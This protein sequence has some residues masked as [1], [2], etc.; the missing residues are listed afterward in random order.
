MLLAVIRVILMSNSG[1]SASGP[2]G[3]GQSPGDATDRSP[4]PKQAESSPDSSLN[5]GADKTNRLSLSDLLSVKTAQD[6]AARVKIKEFHDIVTGDN[7]ESKNLSKV[8]S[9]STFDAI[10]TANISKLLNDKSIKKE[11]SF[12]PQE[13]SRARDFRWTSTRNVNTMSCYRSRRSQA[14]QS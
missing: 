12:N 3:P 9:K 14:G 10:R 2:S 6:R 5:Q 4:E 7:A 11:A 13:E 1:P 8:V